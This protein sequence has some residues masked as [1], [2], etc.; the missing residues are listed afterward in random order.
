MRHKWHTIYIYMC[1]YVFTFIV[2]LLHLAGAYLSVMH[3]SG[4]HRNVGF[5]QSLKD[6]IWSLFPTYIFLMDTVYQVEKTRIIPSLVTVFM[7]V[8]FCQMLSL[9]LLWWSCDFFFFNTVNMVYYLN[10]ISNIKTSLNAWHKSLL[11]MLHNLSLFLILCC[12]WRW[13]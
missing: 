1:M 6:S 13:P 5:P 11:V 10:R 2:A 12:W 7:G 3:R 4:H 8:G 9:C